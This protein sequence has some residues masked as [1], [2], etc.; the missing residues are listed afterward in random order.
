MGMHE[1]IERVAHEASQRLEGHFPGMPEQIE[2][3]NAEQL[4]RA[5]TLWD[6]HPVTKEPYEQLIGYTLPVQSDQ[7]R[8]ILLFKSGD[9][10]VT[11]NRYRDMNGTLHQRYKQH[12]S[13][14]EEPLRFY[15]RKSIDEVIN[16]LHSSTSPWHAK[17]IFRNTNPSDKE[18]ISE[19]MDQALSCA[20]ETKEARERAK[21]ESTRELMRKLDAF[22]NPT[23]PHHNPNPSSDV[24]SS[25]F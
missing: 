20:R 13:P 1:D 2:R 18:R 3:L 10:F 7:N 5:I 12:F 17:I 22:F 14:N 24:P 16:E 9:I 23:K 11:D 21:E 25:E 8:H 6:E 4:G 15:K 19:V